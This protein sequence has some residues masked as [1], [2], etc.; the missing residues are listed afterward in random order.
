MVDVG[1]CDTAL[2]GLCK[3][4]FNDSQLTLLANSDVDMRKEMVDPQLKDLHLAELL[5]EL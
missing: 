1:K 3:G 5:R 4:Q 2:P